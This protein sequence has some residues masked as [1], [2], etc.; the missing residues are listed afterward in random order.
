ML[1]YVKDSSASLLVDVGT[2]TGCLAV[3]LGMERPQA[4]ILAT[5]RSLL[6]I[7]TARKNAARHQVIH[8]MKFCMGDLLA[9]LL[10]PCL[11]GKV[12][13]IIANLPYISHDEWNRL[14][15]EV[16]EFE[17]V[18]ALDGGPDGLGPYRR[19]LHQ[20][21]VLLAPQGVLVLE[22]GR[23]QSAILCQEVNAE[24][25]YTVREIRRDTLD[26]ERVVCLERKE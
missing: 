24:G 9:P 14:P 6:A 2:G 21:G 7:R 10:S 23:G 17:P 4:R 18:L 19:L 8:Q 11:E 12:A 20:A 3:V 25:S 16:R 5:D 26:I 13:G 1:P 22:V 15:R